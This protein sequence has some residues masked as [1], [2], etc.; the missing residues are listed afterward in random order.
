MLERKNLDSWQEI[1]EIVFRANTLGY[2][3][4]AN[5]AQL[6]G[7]VPHF[8]PEGFLHEIYT[9]LQEEQILMMQSKLGANFPISIHDFYGHSNGLNLFMDAISISGLRKNYIRKGDEARQPYDLI[10]SN[11]PGERPRDARPSMVFLGGYGSDGSHLYFDALSDKPDH[12][13][14][15]TR[16][17]ISPLN[18][19]PD[20]WIMLKQETKRISN[21]FTEDGKKKN[22]NL[23]TTP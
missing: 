15:C 3:E 19:W 1:L 10:D 16:K 17:T 21:L 5:G 8:A 6:I 22:P 7:H 12:I 4:C 20:F 23:P 2:R 13:Y 11:R 18:E 14:R 9:P